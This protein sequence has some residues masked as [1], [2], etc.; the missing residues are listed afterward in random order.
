MNTKSIL[1]AT[2]AAA[3]L[4]AGAELRGADTDN[5]NSKSALET[6]LAIIRGKLDS[7]RLVEAPG[8]AARMVWETPEKLRG[9]AARAA[10]E[11]TLSRYPTAVY[12]TVKSVLTVAPDHVVPVMEAVIAKSPK[13]LRAALRAIAEINEGALADAVQTISDKAPGDALMAKSFATRRTG[14]V[15]LAGP[16]LYSQNGSLTIQQTTSSS[17]PPPERNANDYPN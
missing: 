7:T 5:L 4:A 11:A 16:S 10:V 8:V 1:L 14:S 15:K 13:Q 9:D 17:T 3:S 12:S 2:M 6:R